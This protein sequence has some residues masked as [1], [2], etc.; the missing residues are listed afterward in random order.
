MFE[1]FGEGQGGHIAELLQC[2][3]DWSDNWITILR[4]GSIKGGTPGSGLSV[5]DVKVVCCAEGKS[6]KASQQ[7]IVDHLS[8]IKYSGRAPD[9]TE[10]TGKML[11]IHARTHQWVRRKQA[12]GD[13]A[14]MLR[15]VGD[16][17]TEN[18]PLNLGAGR[19][20]EGAPVAIASPRERSRDRGTASSV[21]GNSTPFSAE[22]WRQLES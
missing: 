12:D 5:A 22:S 6:K 2:G 16:G 15:A 8:T 10:I 4:S 3:C 21:A 20:S 17:W 9:V 18:I 13:L 19:A 7:L 1:L 14:R 11:V